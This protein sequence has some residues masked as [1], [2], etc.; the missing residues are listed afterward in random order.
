M[1][2]GIEGSRDRGKRAWRRGSQEE[3]GVMKDSSLTEARVR[4]MEQIKSAGFAFLYRDQWMINGWEGSGS[5]ALGPMRK[6]MEALV[7]GAFLAEV[8]SCN[9][10]MREFQL[11]IF[12]IIAIDIW[13]QKHLEKTRATKVV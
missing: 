7:D 13:R 12:G 11:S 8:E 5:T 3:G 1:G 9:Q 6:T 4:T 2:E 10:F